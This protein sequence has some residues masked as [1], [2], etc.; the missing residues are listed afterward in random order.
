VEDTSHLPQTASSVYSDTYATV[1]TNLC[2]PDHMKKAE[3][4]VGVRVAK[5]PATR[6]RHSDRGGSISSIETGLSKTTHVADLHPPP[7]KRSPPA[8]EAKV[9]RKLSK[10]SPFCRKSV[11][12]F[13]FISLKSQPYPEPNHTRPTN[14]ASIFPLRNGP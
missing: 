14:R 6:M 11:T 7:R 10:S 1:E 8:H 3:T 13:N 12:L 4:E 5:Q 9:K 2:P